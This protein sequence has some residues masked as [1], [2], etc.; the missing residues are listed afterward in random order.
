MSNPNIPLTSEAFPD[1]FN[2]FILLHK[3]ALVITKQELTMKQ[4]TWVL[5]YRAG[6]GW[7]NLTSLP[8]TP[9]ASFLGWEG[10]ER[11]VALVQLRDALPQGETLLDTIFTMARD[12]NTTRGDLLNELS[13]M[14]Q[15]GMT[16]LEFLVGQQGFTFTYPD[17]FKDERAISRIKTCFRFMKRLGMSAEQCLTL[18]RSSVN[19]NVARGVKQAVRAKYDEQ[20][21]LKIARPLR[22]VLRE[23]QRAALVAYLVT[24]PKSI[25]VTTPDG[26]RV[27]MPAWRTVNDLY[28]YFLIDVEMSPCQMTSRIKQAI[29]STQLFVQRCLMGLERDVVADAEVDDKWEQWKWMKNYRVWEANR[30]VFLY[31][32][33]WIEPEL[34]DDKSPFFKELEGEL[35]QNDLTKDS[36]ENAIRH[37]LEKLDDV[38]RLWIVGMYH[39]K[40][41]DNDILHVFGRT[42]VH[43]N[44][45]VHYYRKY[46]NSDNSNYWTA[47]E[48]ADLDI[49]GDHLLPVV[50]NNRLYLFWPVFTEEQRMGS[51]NIGTTLTTEMIKYW[52]I[53]FAWSEYK[54]GKWAPKK[55]LSGKFIEQNKIT[56]KYLTQNS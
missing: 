26:Q 13:I 42:G 1:Q 47:W 24:H 21:W 54:G 27:Y 34:R 17:D 51:V 50:W 55:I 4:L 7:I 20:Q 31:P 46:I 40:E 6:T 53:Q 25:S 14:T 52:K 11:L 30:K 38:A 3:I 43:G 28:A 37:Y 45:Q 16:D 49:E 9:Q 10:W 5:D 41:S 23:K 2:T 8:V 39:E 36:A 44:P 35:M 33:N 19:H 56:F 18:A 15:W 12:G 22:D 29:G 32:E 48:R